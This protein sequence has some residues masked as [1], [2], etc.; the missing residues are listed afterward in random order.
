MGVLLLT[1]SFPSSLLPPA[2]LSHVTCWDADRLVER[3]V[4]ST[5]YLYDVGCGS[6][7]AGCT[8]RGDAHRTVLMISMYV[9]ARAALP[10]LGL[11]DGSASP[12]D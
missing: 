11:V 1:P 4:D 2:L 9:F 8:S 10:A 3:V 6:W 5:L 7:S 12:D